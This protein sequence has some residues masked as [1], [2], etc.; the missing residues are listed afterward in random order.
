MHLFRI[1]MGAVLLLLLPAAGSAQPGVG[2][3]SFAN[4]GAA[5]AQAPFLRGLALLHNFEY[6]SAASAFREAQAADPDFVM[7]YWGEAMTSNHPV[8]K[9]QDAAA[10][11]A[12]L[13]RLAPAREERLAKARTARERAYLEAVEILYGDGAKEERDLLYSDRMRR[14]HEAH[15]EDLDGRAFYALSL[16][17]L[18]HEG[19]DYALYMR[20]AGLLEEVF[21][22][23]RRHPGVLHYLIHSYDDPVHAPLG[24]RAARLYAAVAPDAGHALHMTTHIFVAMG[25]WDEVVAANMN[26]MEVVNRQRAAAGRPPAHCGHYSEWRVYGDYQRRR[27]AEADAQVALCRAD[28][29]EELA[30]S[31]ASGPVEPVRSAVRSYADMAVRR[32]VE[33]GEWTG[34]EGLALPEGR[35][36][37]ARFTLG[38]GALLAA[39]RDLPRVRAARARLREIEERW[40]AAASGRDPGAARRAQIVLMQAE[41]LEQL[42][43]GGTDAGV[44]TLRAAARSEG[45]MPAAFGPP[46]VEKP[47][48]ELLGDVLLRLGRTE[49]ARQA[50]RAATALAPG[51]RLATQALGQ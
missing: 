35:Y 37:A 23:N 36:L 46:L 9:E 47:S 21:P 5:A 16:L 50:Y 29:L 49:E 7:A 18:A 44:A 17:G 13:A 40:A 22:D 34:E 10:G 12:V 31:P 27:S 38:Y 4:S 8:W 51:R 11:R 41:A 2:E 20:A 39:G 19:R 48:H 33:T 24:L 28:A 42:A 1:L 6:F 26:A 30:R 32:L 43:E 45:A 15:P 14:L 25:M 3:V